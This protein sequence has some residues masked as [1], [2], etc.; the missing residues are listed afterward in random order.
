MLQKIQLRW[1]YGIAIAFIL[2]NS[3]LISKEEYW[4][5]VISV[6]GIIFYLGFYHLN[7]LFFLTVLLTPIS[8]NF[9]NEDMN[10]AM[11]LP[12]EPLMIVAMIAFIVKLAVNMPSYRRSRQIN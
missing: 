6:I 1:V 4:L 12:S 7:V 11:S 5:P 10:L 8:V 2:L 9:K 3:L